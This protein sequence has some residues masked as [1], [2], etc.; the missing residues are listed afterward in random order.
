MADEAPSG[1]VANL[2]LDEATGEMIRWAVSPQRGSMLTTIYSK[3][4]LK[5]R[6]KQREQ[7]EKKKAKAA[8]APPKAEKAD[9]KPA[10]AE[11]EEAELTPNVCIYNGSSP[12]AG[13]LIISSNTSKFGRAKSRS[14]ARATGSILTRTNSR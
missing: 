13:L 8:A 5:K 4:E 9:K 1:Q 14:S 2:H 11:D 12:L 6:Q 10:S 3:S 7:E